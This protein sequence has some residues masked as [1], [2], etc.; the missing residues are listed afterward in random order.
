MRIA[1][2][3]VRNAVG[4]SEH[5]DRLVEARDAKLAFHRGERL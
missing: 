4:V 5:L 2:V 3:D 1:R